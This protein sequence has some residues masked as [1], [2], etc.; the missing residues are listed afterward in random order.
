MCCRPIYA[1]NAL[2][3]VKYS[4]PGAR[5][6]TV[7]TTAFEAAPDQGSAEIAAVSSEELD[8]AKVTTPFSIPAALA[9]CHYQAMCS[10]TTDVFLC[11]VKHPGSAD[12]ALSH[13]LP[14]CNC[15]PGCSFYNVPNWL[16]LQRCSIS[17][18]WVEESQP[19][20][21]RPELSAAKLVVAG[22]QY[23][24]SLS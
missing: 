5:L 9:M 11:S 6:L 22:K 19:Q 17:T 21:E 15:L 13:Q 1:G 10:R 3:T 14:M 24:H 4:S 12:V 7:R 2:E 18:Q 23:A 20:T 16:T 8:A